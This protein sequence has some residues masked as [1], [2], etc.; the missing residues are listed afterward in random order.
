MTNNLTALKR[1]IEILS[2]FYPTR[3]V[4]ECTLL[5]L[6]EKYKVAE[7][8]IN[9]DLKDLRSMGIP[10]NSIYGK[11][12]GISGHVN[13]NI[14]SELLVKYIAIFHS[15]IVID[16]S[17]YEI[18]SK[19]NISRVY[20]LSRITSAIDRKELVLIKYKENIYNNIN[21]T[22]LPCVIIHN[23]EDLE[24]IGIYNETVQ[25]YKF[26][27]V[28]TIEET[29]KCN[30]KNYD[31]LINDFL[32][33]HLT[34]SSKIKVRIKIELK[35]GIN[36]Y[37]IFNFITSKTDDDIIEADISHNS[38]ED[39]AF[40]VIQQYGKVKVLEPQI[41]KDKIA[42]VSRLNLFLYDENPKTEV[43]QPS[44]KSKIR[45][46]INLDQVK[47][48]GTAYLVRKP[49][50][51]VE[52]ITKEL[53]ESFLNEIPNK[54]K[55]NAL[56]GKNSKKDGLVNNCMPDILRRA[57]TKYDSVDIELPLKDIYDYDGKK[58]SLIKRILKWIK[59][60]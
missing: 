5:D 24:F 34:P 29:G 26:S 38:I 16:G 44:N 13:P 47:G 18:I 37:K 41:V 23:R 3:Q 8:T 17:L 14:I 50:P 56:K 53:I 54:E 58:P 35:H 4:Q 48:Y 43:K 36:D 25:A 12:I 55:P 31:N 1:Q 30:P 60:N 19:N 57:T 33:K 9:R 46:D 2:M 7:V 40:W 20:S 52:N 15:D 28:L 49:D 27:Q 11:G 22:V 32:V 59:Q 51:E 45:D 42:E 6:A 10:I 39:L 21:V